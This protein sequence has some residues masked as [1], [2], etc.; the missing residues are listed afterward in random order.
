MAEASEL[1]LD[2]W[3]QKLREQHPREVIQATYLDKKVLSYQAVR[4]SQYYFY[5]NVDTQ[6]FIFFMEQ[7]LKSFHENY[8]EDETRS[9][10]LN[11]GPQV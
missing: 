7:I 5:C 8:D 3:L 2:S 10:V 11:I 6:D 4:L 9:P 1:K